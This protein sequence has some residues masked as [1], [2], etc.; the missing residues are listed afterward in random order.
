VTAQISPALMRL[1]R[2]NPRLRS[3]LAAQAR[4]EFPSLL[5]LGQIADLLQEQGSVRAGVVAEHLGMD[6]SVVSRAVASLVDSGHVERLPDPTDGRASLLTL[7]PA[8]QDLVASHRS[9]R[10]ALI[11]GAAADWSAQDRALFAALLDR[12]ADGL[13]R[14][15]AATSDAATSDASTPSV[16]E[17]A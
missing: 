15:L 9:R 8:G 3:R 10:D 16:L 1:M 13:S 5:V 2:N 6:V 14:Y 12:Y 11:E 17:N 4:C 7:T